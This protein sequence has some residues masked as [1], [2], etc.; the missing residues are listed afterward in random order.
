[1]ICDGRSICLRCKMTWV[2]SQQHLKYF[3]LLVQRVVGKMDPERIELF[4][5]CIMNIQSY[6]TNERCISTRFGEDNPLR[7]LPGN[8]EEGNVMFS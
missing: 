4:I 3:C 2:Q 5:S 1:M 7:P 6:V 8:S